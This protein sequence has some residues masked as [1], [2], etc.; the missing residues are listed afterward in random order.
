MVQTV[1]G[2]EYLLVSLLRWLEDV[3][4]PPPDAF[5]IKGLLVFLYYFG[6]SIG[7][8]NQ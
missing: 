6:A 2:C 4:I 3:L 1:L 7:L 8:Y 5:S